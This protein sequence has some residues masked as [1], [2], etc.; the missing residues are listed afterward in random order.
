MVEWYNEGYMADINN[1]VDQQKISLEQ[2][3]QN[4]T[5]KKA[6]ILMLSVATLALVCLAI[7]GLYI[8]RNPKSRVETNIFP[9]SMNAVTNTA[10]AT[11]DIPPLYSGIKWEEQNKGRV[12]FHDEQS[13]IV[14]LNGIL[15]LS[16]PLE[17]YPSDF[18]NYYR[19]GLEKTGW[20]QIGVAGD[21]EGTG[22]FYD[23]KKGSRFVTFGVRTLEGDGVG[24]ALLQYSQ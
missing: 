15:F 14:D 11:A 2:P 18:V 7:L 13:N 22:G 9:T 1:N 10:S 23:Y 21:P 24:R 5:I 19:D 17:T 12:A 3:R 6:P 16:S 8:L 4:S 20:N